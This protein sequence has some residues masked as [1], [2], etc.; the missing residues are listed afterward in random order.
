MRE[1]P[2]EVLPN[3]HLTVWVPASQ[4]T[5]PLCNPDDIGGYTTVAWIGKGDG[6]SGRCG[7]CG[8]KLVLARPNE[9]VP[10]VAEQIGGA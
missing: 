3:D 1:L 10:S 8:L 2:R 4:W 9:H 7:N 5:C 6:P